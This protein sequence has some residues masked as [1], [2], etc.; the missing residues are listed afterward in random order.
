MIPSARISWG[1]LGLLLAVP[2][3]SAAVVT[4]TNLNDSG[5][6]SLRQAIAAAA[7]GDVIVFGVTG[8]ITLTSGHLAIFQ[9]LLING[10]SPSKVAI[11]GNNSDS[12]IRISGGHVS[13]AGVTIRDGR[14]PFGV[15]GGG[16]DFDGLTLSLAN[17]VITNNGSDPD[18]AGGAGILLSRGD[19]TIVNCTISNNG[20]PGYGGGI[21]NI[22][23]SLTIIGS[24]ITANSA[25][26]SGGG[27]AN[28]DGR[29]TMI[30][31]TVEGNSAHAGGGIYDAGA[32]FALLFS[33]VANNFAY[34]GSGIEVGGTLRLKNSL[35]AQ[36]P[37]ANCH[38]GTGAIVSNGYNL[39]DDATC[40]LG[41]TG[42]LS[43]V[44][45]GV[46]PAGPQNN[47][48]PTRTLAL[49]PASAAVNHVP[50]SACVDADGNPVATDQR[51]FSRPEGSACD[52][53]A[54]ELLVM[55]W[56]FATLAL[57]TT[58][59]GLRGFGLGARVVLASGSDGIDPLS[60]PVT[61]T[62]G[63]FT[64]TIPAGSFHVSRFA[65]HRYLF[66][67]AI[68]GVTLD[69]TIVARD[70]RVGFKATAVPVDLGPTSDPLPIALIIG[71]DA[72]ATTVEAT[73]MQE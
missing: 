69:V 6:G 52:T 43:G 28:T 47:G 66:K 72:G 2:P 3:A 25:A 35:I 23:A 16:I 70:G 19:A 24:V 46:D 40:P 29:L 59:S 17:C 5:P 42:D 50:L 33:T 54:Y 62:V 30:N 37:P 10:P 45:A 58:S 44:P 22:A 51:T 9:D 11:S 4:V 53:G 64:T 49:L 7:P 15:R 39:S 63:P 41:G 21:W 20:T 32:P 60:E 27:I 26:F 56:R 18:A 36:N 68:G 13:I 65:P 12:V 55:D 14:A 61:L 38:V 8:T 67:G 34:I 73:G 57:V 31:S 1:V 71:N 48:G